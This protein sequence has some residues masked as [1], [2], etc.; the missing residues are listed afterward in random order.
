MIHLF[1]IESKSQFQTSEYEYFMFLMEL[2]PTVFTI[3][4]TSTQFP[5]RMYFQYCRVPPKT[6]H[7]STSPK[8]LART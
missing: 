5:I 6:T 1:N 4:P 3:K 2:L 8:Q 7:V